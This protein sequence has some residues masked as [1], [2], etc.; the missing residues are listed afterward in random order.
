MPNTL[1][2]QYDKTHAEDHQLVNKPLSN[3]N[4]TLKYLQNISTNEQN[5]K[6]TRYTQI[7]S[8]R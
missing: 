3:M 6:T 5:G 2:Q 1:N 7:S 8:E 4:E